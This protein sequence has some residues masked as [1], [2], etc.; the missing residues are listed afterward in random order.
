MSALFVTL[1]FAHTARAQESKPSGSQN[2]GPIANQTL[3]P[4]QVRAAGTPITQDDNLNDP[5][6]I[7]DVS[8]TGTALEDLPASVQV[9][10]RALLTEQGATTLRQSVSNASGVN[11]GGV[12]ATHC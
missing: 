1:A 5:N 10:P 8:K 9:I 4:V 11:A 12:L 2:G 3:P 6:Q 7:A